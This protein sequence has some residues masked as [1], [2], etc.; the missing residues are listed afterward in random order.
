MLQA[1]GSMPSKPTP[2]PARSPRPW[3][4][5]DCPETRQKFLQALRDAHSPRRAAEIAGIG[6]STAKL[7]KADDEE[8]AKQWEAAYDEGTDIIEDEV[9][10]RAVEGYKEVTET[11]TTGAKGSSSSRS[12]VH[13]YSDTLANLILQGRRPDKYRKSSVELTGPGGGPIKATVE[14]EFVDATVP[15]P[16]GKK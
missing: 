16:K 15:A 4:P 3:T 12:V 8:F 6:L 10:R 14:V 11:E 1:S 7:W 5:K 13:K 2:R 9:R